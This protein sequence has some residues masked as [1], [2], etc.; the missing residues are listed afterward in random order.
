MTGSPY[1]STSVTLSRF[2]RRRPISHARK[3]NWNTYVR[4]IALR[5]Y[6]SSRINIFS[7]SCHARRKHFAQI[8]QYFL[9]F[10]SIDIQ[11]RPKQVINSLLLGHFYPMSLRRRRTIVCGLVARYGPRTSYK[12]LRQFTLPPLV[13]FNVLK[14]RP[15][16]VQLKWNP[17]Y[18]MEL[19]LSRKISISANRTLLL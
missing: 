3:R 13:L 16:E 17:V 18:L 5:E 1:F 8:F 4:F 15:L 10:K 12:R 9:S 11:P 14:S 19:L 7:T 6:R 2:P